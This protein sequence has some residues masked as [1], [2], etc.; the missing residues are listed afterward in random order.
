METCLTNI[1]CLPSFRRVK[2]W[3][4]G[5]DSWTQFDS[6]TPAH[7]RNAVCHAHEYAGTA[8]SGEARISVEVLV[9][10]HGREHGADEAQ[11]SEPR[12]V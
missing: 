10:K 8:I 3:S 7:F 4:C 12:A 1:R 6:W 9:V 11:G 5:C 2:V